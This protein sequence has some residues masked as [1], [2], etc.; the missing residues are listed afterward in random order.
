MNLRSSRLPLREVVRIAFYPNLFEPATSK[1]TVSR[2]AGTLVR[3][4]LALACVAGPI[5][6]AAPEPGVPIPIARASGPIAVDG[7]LSDPGWRGATKITTWYETNPGDNVEPKVR[8]VGYL[9]YDEKFLYAG[10]EFFDPEPGKIRAPYGDRDNVPSST[11]YGG[12]ILDTHGEARRAILFLANPRGIQYDANSDDASGE[13]S[14]PDYYWDSA[15]KIN[16]EGWILELRIPFS[17][18]RYRK[19]DPQNWNIMLYRNHPRDFRYQYFSTK[20]P[21]GGNCFIC[22]SNPLTGLTGLPAGGHLVVAPYGTASQEA[23]PTD[24]PGSELENGSFEGDGG[25][26][27]KWTP[28]VNT[29]I[30]ATLNPDFSQV[31]SDVA[32]I[33]ANERFALFF[34]EKRPFFL[35]GI[36]LF[37]TPIQAV[38]TRTITS[39]RWGARATG[40]FGHTAYTAL[41]AQDRGGGSVIIP[42]PNSSSLAEQDF[43][44]IAA[45]A[46]V[47]HELGTSFVSFLATDREIEDGGYN[48]V[49]GPDFRWSPGERDTVTGQ[50]LFSESETPDRPDL[51]AEWNGQKLSGHAGEI[52]WSHSTKTWDWFTGYWDFSDEFRADNGFVPQVGAR[53]NY[54]EAGYTFRP[55]SGFLRRLRTFLQADYQAQRDGALIFRQISPGAGMDGLFASFL[56]FQIA[57]DKVRAGAHTFDRNRFLYVIEGSPSRIFN[58]VGIDGNIGEQV[59]FANSR[60]GDGGTVNAFA[61][62]RPTDHLELRFN[63]SRQW[64]D[65]DT[66]T[67]KGRLFTASVARL[68]AQYTFTARAFLRVIGQYVETKRDPSL[69]TFTVSEKDASFTGSVLVAYK[70][71]WQSVLF[72]GY[73]DERALSED[74]HLDK[75]GRQ[76]FLKLSYAFQL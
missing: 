17:S 63:G 7:D 65:V 3:L 71:N 16:R 70:L 47:R 28:S 61:T 34:P 30:D 32:Q 43:R 49:L 22:R 39:P 51:T 45:I 67:A 75:A 66:E 74:D 59:D 14:S 69:Y 56:R 27:V 64:L 1:Q 68:R 10:F 35:E 21:R 29:A 60:P 42:G 25:V 48:R 58:R 54:G 76:F 26:D 50:I 5:C 57:F 41:V 55:T 46:R 6:A 23:H 37:A 53:E 73:G 4:V 12:I 52:W 9:T 33:S 2:R 44:S 38:Y 36:E 24:G 11:D 19:A 62:I 8:N 72:V 18:L 13:D 40:K 20:L 15:A 31:E